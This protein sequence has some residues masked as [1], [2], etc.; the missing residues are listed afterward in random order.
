MP[1]FL[2]PAVLSGI[3]ALSGFLNNRKQK[4]Q[5]EQT[6]TTNSTDSFNQTTNPV[7]S[8][9]ALNALSVLMPQLIN[10]ANSSTDLSGYTASGLQ[11]IN[12]QN[13]MA[14]AKLTQS[15]VSRGLNNSPAGAALA[16]RSDDAGAYNT[17]NFLNSIPLLQR[18]MQGEDLKS[19]LAAFSA[20]PTGSSTSGTST[21]TGT[22]TSTGSATTPGNMLGGAIEGLGQGIASTFGRRW[23]AIQA[24]RLGRRW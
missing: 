5:Q 19:L 10:R 15:L 22:T 14:R 23:A 4:T 6:S 11:N 9:E 21:R 16:A 2:F 17:S 3:S 7:L 18:Q 12:A 1:A 13:E 24:A 20:I 8:P